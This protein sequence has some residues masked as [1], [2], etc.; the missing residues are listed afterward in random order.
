[1]LASQLLS[2][3]SLNIS[4]LAAASVAW[5]RFRGCGVREC[6]PMVVID[7]EPNGYSFDSVGTEAA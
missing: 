2:T 1:M 4:G 7:A 5:A 6:E 3:A